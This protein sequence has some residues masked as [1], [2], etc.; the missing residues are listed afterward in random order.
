MILIYVYIAFLLSSNG[1]AYNTAHTAAVVEAIIEWWIRPSLKHHTILIA[2]G[3]CLIILGQT[4]RALAMAHAAT[5]FNHHVAT[6]HREGH[7][8]VKT[9]VYQYVLSISVGPFLV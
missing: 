1:V 9:G 8:L 6:M 3:L 5:N 4:V 7:V 2:L